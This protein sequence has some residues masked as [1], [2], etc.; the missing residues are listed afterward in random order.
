MKDRII[1]V[2]AKDISIEQSDAE[3]GKVMGTAVGCACGDGVV[4]YPALFEICRKLPQDIVFSV[5]CET[6][7]QAER[8][9]Q[10]FKSIL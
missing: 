4:D 5:E 3:R 10:Y 2:H 1:H 7:E 8:S 9:I 6:L